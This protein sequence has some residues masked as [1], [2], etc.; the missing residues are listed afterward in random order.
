MTRILQ[1]LAEIS[2]RY[3][4]LLCDLWGCVHNG[5]A[6]F[7]AALAALQGFRGQGGRVILITNAPRPARFVAEGLDRMGVPREAW[8]AIVTSGD[9]A[10]DAMFAGAVGR[11][12]W[13]LGPQKDDGFFTEIPPEWE[14]RSHVQLVPFDQAEGIVCTGPFDE[15]N[16]VPEDYRPRF[17]E[18]KTRGLPMLCANPDVVVDMGATRIYCAGALA[19]LYEEMGGRTM[20]FGKPH[21]PIYDMARRRMAEFGLA[22]DSR[23]LAVGD[24]INTDVAG[25][26][27][28]NLDVLFVSGGL[29]AEQFGA[30]VE[31]PNPDLLRAWLDARQQ[32]PQYTIGRLR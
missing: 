2:A 20:Y 19:A 4:V 8:D 12:L 23:V 3:D 28:E 7:P 31:N 29:A 18:A 9:A 32:D 11:R 30:D 10:Q 25:A 27:G 26:I 5:V 24:G 6:P 16:E 22:D 14:G 1:S 13:H 15:L 21:P 17:L